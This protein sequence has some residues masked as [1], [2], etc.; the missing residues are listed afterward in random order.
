MDTINA[1][2]EDFDSLCEEIA[3]LKAKLKETESE[4][5][6]SQKRT[7]IAIR[8]SDITIFDY[9][10]KTKKIITHPKDYELF[11]M[12]GILTNGVE[13]VLNSGIIAERSKQA[14]RDLYQRID[15][16]EPT[17]STIIFA[18]T[19]SGAERTLALQM[20]T[21]YNDEGEPVYAV[22]VRKDITEQVSFYHEKKYADL[23]ASDLNF[24]YEA[25]I[26][27]D[28]LLDFEP[29]WARNI[30]LGSISTFSELLTH[31]AQH[32]IH[33][34]DMDVF[35]QH[36]SKDFLLHSF[37]QGTRIL[38]FEYRKK[39]PSS[40]YEWYEIRINLIQDTLN[41]DIHMR[42]Y[43]SNINE[44]K[45]NE[46]RLAA[47]HMQYE[48]IVSKSSL[49]YQINVSKK[50]IQLLQDN[51][52]GRYDI[53]HGDYYTG[54]IDPS[55]LALIHPLDKATIAYLISL[56]NIRYSY[57]HQDTELKQ[58]YRKM[59]INGTYHWFRCTMQIF[60]DT[61]EED[62]LCYVYIED[63]HEEKEQELAL[64]Y[65]SQHDALTGFYTKNITSEKV[66]EFLGTPEA[67][68]S[69]HA[70]FIIDLDHFKEINDTFG[71][72]FGDTVLAQTATKIRSLFR[73][74][75]IF[76]R[77]GGDEFVVFMKH[78]PS[79]MVILQ[80]SQEI[81]NYVSDVYEFN[82]ESY[83]VTISIGVALYHSHGHCFNEL[84]RHSDAA[85]YVAK[86]QGR[87]RFALYY[88][89]MPC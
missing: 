16:G 34:E 3:L 84:Y 74:N 39:T 57:A 29:Q 80:K 50:T 49:V 8:F 55:I 25:N 27:H 67:Q 43:I 28:K 10:I 7:E 54:S 60:K 5:K 71:H 26:T 14:I 87:N 15:L 69:T 24:I 68:S 11:G 56:D 83:G 81:C 64:I 44:R 59:D 73:S 53:F 62:L 79:E 66:D 37:E 18:T 41:Q 12:P 31:I 17:A 13:E 48:L 70:F 9:N 65:R 86:E 46:M 61:Q 4:L 76:G 63:I 22:G 1:P 30:H 72:T 82:G 78:I 38:T 47:E 75:D 35:L 58:D 40:V 88:D 36:Q 20:V 45:N 23:I 42:T 33:P 2:H 77:I 89:G 21:L 85:L 52:N 19:Q 51:L 32:Y 6:M